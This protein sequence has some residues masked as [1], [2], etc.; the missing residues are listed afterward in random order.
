MTAWWLL[1]APWKV[2]AQRPVARFTKLW[3]ISRGRGPIVPSPFTPPGTGAAVPRTIP[4]GS[5]N[6]KETS[7]PAV[8]PV[9]LKVMVVPT[10]P[11]LGVAVPLTLP[12]VSQLVVWA[13]ALPVETNVASNS[14]TSIVVNLVCLDIIPPDEKIRC[15][16]KQ[17]EWFDSALSTSNIC[18]NL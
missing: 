5:V 8:K 7:S 4:L 1:E 10:V 14:A 18:A 17:T 15:G 13:K 2:I 11:V 9:A 6:Q 16:C 3:S 12:E